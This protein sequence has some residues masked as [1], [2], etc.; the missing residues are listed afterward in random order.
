MAAN[1]GAAAR[2]TAIYAGTPDDSMA[3]IRNQ[4]DPAH[5]YAEQN[6]LLVVAEYVD[7]RGERASSSA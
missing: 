3:S 1:R 7:L 6:D 5:S 2:R 4:L